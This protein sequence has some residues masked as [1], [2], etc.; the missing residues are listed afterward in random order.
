MKQIQKIVIVVLAI[1]FMGSSQPASANGLTLTM[2]RIDRMT[3][4]TPSSGMVCAK[5]H[6][7]ATEASIDV[8]FPTG[9]ILNT[10]AANWT[11]T[12]TNILS[13]AT[14]W[15]SIGTATSV[16]GTTVTFPSGDLLVD[17]LYCFNF[18]GTNTLTT[19]SVGNSQSGSFTTHA[20]DTS[21]IDASGY[22]TAV[23]DND[24]VT[25]SGV[26]PPLFSMDLSGNV[27]S[28]VSPLSP[29]NVVSTT[30]TDVTI[31][32][33]ANSGWVAW[34]KSA[35]AELTSASTGKVIGTYGVIDDVST[36]LA[37]V[38][39]QNAYNLNVAI[40]TDSATE[41]TG[42]VS[43]GAGYG[44]EYAG[45]A[46]EAGTLSTTFQAI[47]A[48][49][50]VTDGDVLT[51]TERAKITSLQQAATDYADTLTVVAAGRF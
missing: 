17:T 37:L 50:G 32:T 3:T 31:G 9:F 34:V 4:A 36:D 42:T 46:T 40:K 51:L 18:S 28:F 49:S 16:S 47:A 24:H 10:T 7:V 23:V 6:T 27:D 11:V 22:L 48:G 5:T 33:N 14:P 39:G 12:T 8:T 1:C 35:N 13:N 20:S 29:T 19:G 15:P 30:G 38:S 26:V 43:Q 25:V 2:L 41:G 44:Q 45:G 21:V